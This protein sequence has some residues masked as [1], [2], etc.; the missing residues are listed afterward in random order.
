MSSNVS[1]VNQA[2]STSRLTFLQGM[3]KMKKYGEI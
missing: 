2:A 3:E 1:H